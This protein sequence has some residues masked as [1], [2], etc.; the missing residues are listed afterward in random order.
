MRS[1]V[2]VGRK[3]FLLVASAALSGLGHLQLFQW[4]RDRSGAGCQR[5]GVICQRVFT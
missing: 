1:G 5:T 2:T 3:S 4:R